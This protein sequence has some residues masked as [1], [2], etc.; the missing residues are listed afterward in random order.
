MYFELLHF[1]KII[2]RR[3]HSPQLHSDPQP[4]DHQTRA[5]TIAPKG[6]RVVAII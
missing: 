4:A 2:L 6:T 1:P 5:L 3:A